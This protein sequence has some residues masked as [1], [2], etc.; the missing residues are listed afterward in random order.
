[1]PTFV[2]DSIE[3]KTLKPVVP[4][5]EQENPSLQVIDN[6]SDLEAINFVKKKSVYEATIQNLTSEVL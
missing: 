2:S 4:Q 1:M 5:P 3:P 6:F